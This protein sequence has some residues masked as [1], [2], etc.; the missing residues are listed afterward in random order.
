MSKKRELEITI[1]E[2]GKLKI[3]IKGF[4]GKACMDVAKM[5][6]KTLGQIEDVEHTSEYYQPEEENKI[7]LEKNE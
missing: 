3:H 7:N 1:G 5:L 4:P 2:D 6:E